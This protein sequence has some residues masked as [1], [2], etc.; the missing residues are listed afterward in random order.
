[1]LQRCAFC[2]KFT[3]NP[4]TVQAF[5]QF[6]GLTGHANITICTD[7]LYISDTQ[8]DQVGPVGGADGED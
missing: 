8:A 1:M 6:H 4:R 5:V 2:Q 3:D 7:C